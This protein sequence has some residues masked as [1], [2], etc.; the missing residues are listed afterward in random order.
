MISYAAMTPIRDTISYIGRSGINLMETL[1]FIALG[2]ININDTAVQIVKT[3]IGSIFIILITQGFIGLAVSTQL[4]KEFQELGAVNLIGGF[5]GLA[6]VRELAPV[7]SAIVVASRVGA[8]IAAEIGSM[9]VSEQVDALAVFGINPIKYLLVPRF[10]AASIVTPLLTVIAALITIIA[11]MLLSNL[12]VDVSYAGYLN[13]VRQYVMERDVYIMML[14]SVMFGGAIAIIATTTGL[15]V[16][17]GAESVGKA[18][19]QTVVWSI[20]VIFALNYI[21]TSMFF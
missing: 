17:N 2:M 13:S 18:A 20:I 8:G 4:A 21:I 3:G 15:E 5:I 9:K 6:S 16:Q 1:R 11:G 7:I 10:I 19:T 14:K 12:S